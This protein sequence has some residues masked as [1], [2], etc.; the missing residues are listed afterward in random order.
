M[1]KTVFEDLTP[2]AWNKRLW[3]DAGITLPF[4]IYLP[5]PCESANERPSILLFLHGD[6]PR[7]DDN[8][9][10]LSTGEST[11]AK[12]VIAEHGNCIVLA[13]HC[14]VT[15]KWVL[16]EKPDEYR[17]D[18]ENESPY[19]T[20]AYSLLLAAEAALKP[21]PSRVYLNGYSR[22]TFASWWLLARYPD[23]FAA[24]VCFSGSGDPTKADRFAKKVPVWIFHGDADT[25]IAFSAFEKM[26][27]AIRAAGG[28]P[29]TTVCHGA[30]HG[31][32]PFIAAEKDLVSWLFA[33]KKS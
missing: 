9:K 13:P 11:L 18:P 22:G 33:Q 19:L 32:A 23:H 17:L 6:G 10:Q 7:G 24:A 31:I 30:G 20:A 26:R 28:D 5:D 4:Q 16:E 2:G 12:R 3:Q 1:E 25:V 14:P 15:S 27:D 8:E 29:K 21:D